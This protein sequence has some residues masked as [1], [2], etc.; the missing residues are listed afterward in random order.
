MT[1][2]RNVYSDITAI[3]P[4]IF[5]DVCFIA[6]DNMIMPGLVKNFTD[7]TGAA[8]RDYERYGSVLMGT[9]GDGDDLVSQQVKPSSIATITPAEYAAQA[10]L[11][12]LKVESDPFNSIADAKMELGLAFAQKLDTDILGRFNE[13]TAGTVGTS[14]SVMT[15]GYVFAMQA[16]LRNALAPL[17][18]T[19]VCTPYQAYNL[20]KSA[21][22]GA[23]VTNSPELQN[24]LSSGQERVYMGQF[25]GINIFSSV[26]CE[27]SSTDA[28]AGMF[29]PQAIALDWRRAPRLEVE[30]DGSRRATELNFSAVIAQGVW[31]PEWGV[32]GIFA[33]SAVTGV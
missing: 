30:R 24:R 4:S 16:V 26:Y 8:V 15:W 18:Y 33:N 20:G 5:E 28:Y 10:L 7:R 3:V 21:S 22:V 14:G 12:D 11:T 6:R 19:L 31:R 17:P 32:C 27:A 2:G 1:V 9:I 25:F 23:T 29:S 13:L